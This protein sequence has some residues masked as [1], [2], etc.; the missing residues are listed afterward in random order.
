MDR[1]RIR[2]GRELQGSV[3]VS[4]SKNASLPILA[5]T[6]LLDG[7]VVL[8]NVPR[9]KDIAVMIHLLEL[10]GV[11]VERDQNGDLLC[12]AVDKTVYEAPY[13]L[14][15][16]MRAS[17]VVLGPLWA[18]RGV[19][20]VSYPGGCLLGHR[21][22][23]LHIKGLEALGADMRIDGRLRHRD[24]RPCSSGWRLPRRQLR[25]DGARHGQHRDGRDPRSTARAISRTRRWSRRSSISATS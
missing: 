12:E 6:L 16:K 4:G 18:R 19:G 9:L 23:D 14:V 3:T 5:A 21:P 17:F 24:R 7:P 10:L 20:R 25:L 11:R 2:G 1:I 8:R 15:R 22:V 13:D